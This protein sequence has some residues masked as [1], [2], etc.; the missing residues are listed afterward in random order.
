MIEQMNELRT[1]NRKLA[2]I[3]SNMVTKEEVEA[4]KV[5][6]VQEANLKC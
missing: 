6:I 2:M 3:V 4:I 1:D 5:K